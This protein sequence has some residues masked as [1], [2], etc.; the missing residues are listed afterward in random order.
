MPQQTLAQEGA[1]LTAGAVFAM[2]NARDG[3]IVVA[4]YRNAN[5][6]LVEAGR[7]ATGGTGSGSFED[8]SNSLVLG[9]RA[10]ESAPNNLIEPQNGEQQ[11]LFVTNAGSNTISV[12][13]VHEDRLE[14][15]DVQDSNGEKPISIIVNKGLVYVLNSGETNDNLFDAEGNVIVNCTTGNQKP[16]IRGFTLTADGQLHALKG[17][18]RKLSGERVSG[19]AQVSFDPTGQL[20]VVTERLAQPRRLHQ[21]RSTIEWLDDEGLIVTFRVNEGGRPHARKLI[22]ATG[23]GPFGFTFKRDGDLL[24]TG[25]F[26]VRPGRGTAASYVLGTVGGFQSESDSDDDSESESGSDRLNGKLLHS[27]SSLRT[28]NGTLT[29]IEEHTPFPQPSFGPGGGEAAPIGLAAS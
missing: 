25:Q 10:G 9:T 13:A 11:L 20:L 8:T 15:L 7:F 29:L 21:Q 26:D 22:D 6:T 16:N 3:N 23:Q 5:G 24:T 4:Y 1:D 19:C 14:L 28:G 27:S 18:G 2:S 12:F 17:S